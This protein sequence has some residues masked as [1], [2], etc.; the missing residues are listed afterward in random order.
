MDAPTPQI[1]YQPLTTLLDLP[2]EL[3]E[4]IA[5]MLRVS[6]FEED[7]SA[8]LAEGRRALTALSGVC[9]GLREICTPLMWQVRRLSRS[10]SSTS[11]RL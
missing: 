4:H 2:P 5:G 9:R 7:E 3:L 10:I 1:V 8:K 6:R 11:S